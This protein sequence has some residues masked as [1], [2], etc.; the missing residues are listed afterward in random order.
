MI[1]LIPNFPGYIYVYM[2]NSFQQKTWVELIVQIIAPTLG[3]I[4]VLGMLITIKFRRN[5]VD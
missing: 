5:I 2:I 1:E 4:I 3:I